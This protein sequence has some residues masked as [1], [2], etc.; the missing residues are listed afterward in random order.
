MWSETHRTYTAEREIGK[1][2]SKT[3]IK[4]FP[5]MWQPIQ[6]VTQNVGAL[7]TP[8]IYTQIYVKQEWPQFGA[9][10]GGNNVEQC[11]KTLKI[12]QF[13][14]ET[15]GDSSTFSFMA[16]LFNSAGLVLYRSCTCSHA[17]EIHIGHALHAKQSIPS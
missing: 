10:Y 9:S 3:K 15:W 11:H 12:D 14:T 4:M 2:N 17:A 16:L 6:T 8:K 13:L 7:D 5:R 1:K